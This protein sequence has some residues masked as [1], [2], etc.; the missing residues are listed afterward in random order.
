MAE[1]SLD[2]ITIL[3]VQ[4]SELYAY[5]E[6]HSLGK[7]WPSELVQ[8][9]VTYSFEACWNLPVQMKSYIQAARYLRNN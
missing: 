7:D 4:G 1:L 6:K 3:S 9:G 8:D 5:I 2:E